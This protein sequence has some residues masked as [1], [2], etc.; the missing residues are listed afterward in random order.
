MRDTPE[1]P[2]GVASGRWFTFGDGDDLPDDQRPDDERSVCFDGAPVT[3]ETAII[4]APRVTVACR[5][6]GEHVTTHSGVVV[7]RV[8]AVSP[9][10]SSHRITYG[11]CNVSAMSSS[12]HGSVS[13]YQGDEDE[14]TF[15]VTV[16]C[17]YCAFSIPVGW[18]LRVGLSPVSY[19]HLTLPTIYS[20]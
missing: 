7:A 15:A 5:R 9:D 2:V 14:S 13:N 17:D 16:A 12:S 3:V 8:C 19:T 10:G 6:V 18:K 20:V 4:G 11:V 1:K